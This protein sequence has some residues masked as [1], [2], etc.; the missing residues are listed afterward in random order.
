VP[1]ADLTV[2]RNALAAQIT[3]QTGLR[4]QAQVRDQ[5]SP[6][7]ALVLPGN[8][9]I[10]FGA[11][12]D[13]GGMPEAVVLNLTIALLIS[14]AAPT[15]KVQR[16]IDAYLG[17]GAGE[18]VSIAGAIMADNSLGGAVHWCIPVAVTSYGRIEFAAET[19]FG[20]RLNV[21]VGAV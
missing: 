6:P 3:A 10:T 7:V 13:G 21:S 19:Y 14:D 12:M 15:E 20:G 5:V 11:T 9:L 1:V 18:T 16:A 8:P 17:I 4:A 2:I